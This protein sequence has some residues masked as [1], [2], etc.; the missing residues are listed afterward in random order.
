MIRVK[1][2]I[3]ILKKLQIMTITFKEGFKIKKR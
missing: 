3:D 2:K 1:T